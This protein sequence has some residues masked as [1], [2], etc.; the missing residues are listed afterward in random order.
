MM[1][2]KVALAAATM[3]G[4]SAM[5][6]AAPAVAQGTRP[7]AQPAAPAAGQAQAA[8]QP[9]RQL[10]I[11]RAEAAALQPLETAVRAQNWPAAQA[12]LPAAQAA[13]QGPDARYFV[14]RAAFQIAVR[15]NNSQGEAQALDALIGMPNTPA[16]EKNVF[17]NRR[18]EIA[19]TAQDF[20]RA[21]QIYTQLAQLTPN[22][23]RVQQNLSVVR[24][25]MGNS[26]GAVEPIQQQIRTAEAAGQTA[27]EALYRRAFDIHRAARQSPQAAEAFGRLLRAYPTSANW[28]LGVDIAR[29]G[30]GS[31][32]QHL[33]DVFRF[34][35][36]ANVVQGSEYV[37]FANTL[38]QAGFPGE[39]RAVLDAGIAAG[40]VQRG[41]V[42]QLLSV[43]DRRIAEDRTGLPGQISQARSASS[44]RQARVAADTLYGYG[45]YQEAADLYR[46]ALTKGG[47]DANMV[48][49]RLGASLAMAGQRAPAEAALRSV[50]G[51]RADLAQLWLAWLSRRAA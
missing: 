46:L 15:T 50:T 45:R 47:E 41:Q 10:Q 2:S 7:A 17:L 33:V 34:A 37:A 21:E 25:R 36:A 9:Q 44:G 16:N 40:A 30:A 27:P 20:T 39:T 3:V 32:V 11:S 4:G 5:L 14:A 23:P 51:G 24:S 35:R 18:A 28:R 8:G 43:S 31:D 1:V 42:S 19:F 22:D 38:N 26:A 49:T 6:I 12:A 29:Q 48:N 13:A